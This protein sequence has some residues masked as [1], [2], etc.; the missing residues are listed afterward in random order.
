MTNDTIP[1]AAASEKKASSATAP[2]QSALV[3]TQSGHEK[4]RDETRQGFENQEE[5]GGGE[6]DA[7][8]VDHV[9]MHKVR[10]LSLGYI[11]FH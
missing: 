1:A 3:R 2:A 11:C 5:R 6:A 4:A 7:H 8:Y 9:Y 10:V